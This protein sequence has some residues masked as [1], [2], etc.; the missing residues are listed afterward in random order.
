MQS[1][2]SILT[3]YVIVGRAS[4]AQFPVIGNGEVGK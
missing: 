2:A 1:R 4:E 3:G